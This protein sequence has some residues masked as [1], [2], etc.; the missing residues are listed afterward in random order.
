MRYVSQNS[1]KMKDRSQ[2]VIVF[3]IPRGAST[4]RN[5]VHRTFI[6]FGVKKIQESVWSSDNS[7]L[8]LNVAE[9]IKTQ[10]GKV[11]VF[12]AESIF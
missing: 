3:D 1:E 8:L 4:L 5:R 9:Q 12:R 7:S 11:K 10:G 2:F 6:K